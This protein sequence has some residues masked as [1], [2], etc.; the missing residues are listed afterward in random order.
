MPKPKGRI[1]KG[2]LSIIGAFAATLVFL[3]APVCS[4]E[5]K[6]HLLPNGLKI[7]TL[8]NHKAPVVTFQIWYKVGSRNEVTGKTG[9]SHL[10][11]HM[12]LKGTP[13]HGKGEF[14]RIVSMNGGN[15]NAFTSQDYTAYFEIFS[16]NRLNISLELE[17]DRMVTILE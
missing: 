4:S 7:V 3:V 8:E 5:I 17:S 16:I 9:I 13:S 15:E 14:S 1:K 11:E 10:L 6:D 12:M 2:A